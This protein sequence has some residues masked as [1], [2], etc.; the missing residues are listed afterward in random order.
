VRI[1]FSRPLVTLTSIGDIHRLSDRIPSDAVLLLDEAY[2]HYAPDASGSILRSASKEC[3]KNKGA[4]N[5]RE[6]TGH[7]TFGTCITSR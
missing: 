6:N 5:K 3:R 2:I 7:A 4:K 1:P